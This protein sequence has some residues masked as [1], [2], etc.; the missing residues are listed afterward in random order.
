MKSVAAVLFFSLLA[1]AAQAAP[2]AMPEEARSPM[3]QNHAEQPKTEEVQ[4]GSS[5]QAPA[6]VAAIPLRLIDRA[7]NYV[8]ML[9]PPT[10]GDSHFTFPGAYASP[11]SSELSYAM[12]CARI[13]A[14]HAGCRVRVWF[15]H[16]HPGE[17]DLVDNSVYPDPSEIAFA[18]GED[19]EDDESEPCVALGVDAGDGQGEQGL[20]VRRI[21]VECPSGSA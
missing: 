14:A 19:D 6:P 11:D 8:Q 20:L 16:R 15:D 4:V 5:A 3:I 18:E 17:E 13:P 21:D 12:V 1:S 9:E 10:A 2:A 7:G